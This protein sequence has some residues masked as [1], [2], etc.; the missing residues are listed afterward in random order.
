MTNY[1]KQ[2]QKIKKAHTQLTSLKFQLLIGI[3]LRDLNIT[4]QK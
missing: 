2:N 1:R 3:Q 4:C